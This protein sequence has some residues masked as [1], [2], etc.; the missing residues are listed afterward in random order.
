MIPKSTSCRAL[1]INNIVRKESEH[2]SSQNIHQPN[3]TERVTLSRENDELRQQLEQLRSDVGEGYDP[4]SIPMKTTLD[5]FDA[6]IRPAVAVL[7]D[8]S[9]ADTISRNNIP[10]EVKI[11]LVS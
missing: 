1:D 6:D 8:G 9:L 2:E 4:I 11:V 10:N 3:E 5:Q 7:K